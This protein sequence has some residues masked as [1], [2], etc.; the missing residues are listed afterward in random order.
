MS[1]SLRCCVLLVVSIVL[2]VDAFAQPCNMNVNATPINPQSICVGESLQL[3]SNINN[4]NNPYTYSWTPTAGLSDPTIANPIATPTTTTVYTLTVTDDDNCTASDNITVTVDPT[5]D[6]AMT[7][8]NSQF[9]V[10]N[11]VPTFY[12]CLSNATSSFQFDFAG[13]AMPGSTHTI[14]WGDGSPDFTATGATW[15]QQAHIY[16]QGIH[17]ITYTISQPNTCND[18]STYSVFLG[19][20]PSGSLDN[21]GGTVG[22][23][24]LTLTFPIQGT[25]G[26]TPGTLYIVTF[27]DGTPPITLTHPPPLDIT[28]TFTVGS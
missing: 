23:G 8:G 13:T 18:V 3:N 4:G 22:C 2:G 5:A 24:P 12:K 7:S 16:S 27:N 1:F 17:T 26:N 15:P 10:F 25:A 20:N 11:G 28:H 9:T 19:T 14:D 6:A 21:P